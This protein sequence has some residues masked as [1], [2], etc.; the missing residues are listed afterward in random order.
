MF[1]S[2][3]FLVLCVLV[4]LSAAFLFTGCSAGNGEVE[5]TGF[6]PVGLWATDFD[7]YDITGGS[8]DYLMDNSSWN[9]ENDLLQGQI[10]RAVDFSGNSGVLI[11]RVNRASGP[12]IA[13][14][15]GRY[16][17]VYYRD[18]SGSSI[19]LANA[20]DLTDWSPIEASSISAAETLFT[21][22]NSHLHVDWSFVTPYSIAHN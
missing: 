6:I 2:R 4:C 8:L 1:L 11:I 17:G 3:K 10:V 5:N 18:Y 13:N 16:T 21:L 15:V 9:P 14:T 19:R 7:R 12:L 20:V 22:D